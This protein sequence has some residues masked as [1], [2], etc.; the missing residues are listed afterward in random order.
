MMTFVVD[1]MKSTPTSFDF[2]IC[3]KHAISALVTPPIKQTNT[4]GFFLYPEISKDDFVVSLARL[5]FFES[6]W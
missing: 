5:I 4:T 6:E 1:T 2:D 3:R